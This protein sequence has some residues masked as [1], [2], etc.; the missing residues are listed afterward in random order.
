MGIAFEMARAAVR[1]ALFLMPETRK[2]SIWK[3]EEV[4]AA[5]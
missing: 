5:A 3:P 4:K 2:M 1:L